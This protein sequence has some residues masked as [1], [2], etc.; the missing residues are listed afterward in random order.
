MDRDP[1]DRILYLLKS[2]GPQSAAQLARR[3]GVTA[4]AVRQ[5]LYALERDAMVSST[6]ERRPVGRPLRRWSV[7]ERAAARFPESHAELTLEMIAAV[8]ATFGEKGLD[9]LLA[10]RTRLQ[11]RQ[12]RERIR[13]SSDGSL[14]G[15]ARALAAIRKEQG[16]MAECAARPDGTL[17]LRENHCPICVAAKS[18]QGLCREEL[19]L[20]RAVLGPHTKVERT[21]HILAGASRCAY[22][23]TAE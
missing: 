6:D 14:E 15:R 2:K 1:K 4:M 17:L 22:V 20:F 9:R 12:Y 19:G 3:L 7:T 11:L 21:D 18:C 10:E 5:H 23:I 16:Y 8:R 13:V